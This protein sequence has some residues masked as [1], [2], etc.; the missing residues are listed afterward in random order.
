[1]K[2]NNKQP[3]R[4]SVSE[5]KQIL[6]EEEFAQAK[7]KIEIATRTLE[8]VKS[9]LSSALFLHNGKLS[10][11]TIDYAAFRIETLS[12]IFEIAS[13][14]FRISAKSGP[15]AYKE[16][17]SDLGEEV[18]FSFAR[19]L[20]SRLKS[21]DLFL[22][23]QKIKKLL[24]LWTLF[25]N[26]T[27]AGETTL[28]SCSREKI[29]I[30]LRNN[31]LRRVESSPHAHCGFYSNYIRSLVNELHT[32]RARLIQQEIE[33]S[34]VEALK[35]VNVVENP[36]ADDNCVFIA[37]LRPEI[38]SRS[39]DAL[40]QA[41]ELFYRLSESED[42]SPCLPQ[43]RSA[44]VSA[45]MESIGLEGERPP[46]QLFKIFKNVIQKN[47]FRRMK[48]VYQ[49]TSKYIHSES[50]S[51][52]RLTSIHCQE[53]LRDVRRSV[54]AFEFLDISEKERDDLRNKA[55]LND[56]LAVFR[57]LT[58]LVQKTEEL[59]AE[60]KNETVR[61]LSQVKNGKVIEEQ[62]QVQL[63]QRLRQLG[64]HI[65]EVAKPILTEVITAAIKKQSGL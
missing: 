46:R 18:G 47:D 17:L 41:Y 21:R 31:P 61:L 2:S 9:V 55:I 30:H 45:Q 4:L 42:F 1:M 62:S 59:D 43:A 10:T 53:I 28:T 64:G 35:V 25:E 14:N 23:V 50:A 22:E 20:L 24:Q 5:V 40:Y 36:D 51:R 63:V 34:K 48:E 37:K 12:L 26:E 44:L 65:W 49:V 16:F 32:V 15:E 19:G 39:F 58:E 54:Y 8:D 56:R 27:G 29:V 13:K 33:E 6:S 38:L 60:E 3:H 52:K 57:E 11:G 7:H